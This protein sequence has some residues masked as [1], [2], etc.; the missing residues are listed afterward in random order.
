MNAQHDL[1]ASSHD[2]VSNIRTIVRLALF[3]AIIAALGLL[4]KFDLPLL[5]GIPVT[6]QTLGVMLAGLF[7]GARNGALAVLLFLFVVALG[8]PF[9]SGGRGG[10]AVFYGPSVGYLIGWVAG[11]FVCGAMMQHLKTGQGWLRT[12]WVRAWLSAFIGGLLVVH[13]FGIAVL[14]WK[15]NLGLQQAALLELAFVPGDILKTL[16]AA[17][18]AVA[19][20]RSAPSFRLQHPL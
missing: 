11:A 18:I 14:A 12:E 3:A 16:A 20:L 19:V 2:A 6:A 8:A 10:L 1:P 4:P 9:L 13:V 17:M 7:L 5:P 15:A